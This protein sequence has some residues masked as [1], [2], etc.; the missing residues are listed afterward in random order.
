METWITFASR[1]RI[2]ILRPDGSDLH[3]LALDVPGQVNW[4]LGPL[5]AD[6]ER[7]IV[8]SYEEG[9]PWE[10]EVHTHLWMYHFRR[11]TLQE[12]A[13]Q[14]RLTPMTLCAALLPGETRMI[15]SPIIQHEQRIYSM[16]LDGSHAQELTGAGEGFAYG[17]ALSPDGRHIAHHITGPNDLPYRI[18]VMNVDG[19]H[20][21]E[22]AHQAGHLYFG[23][24]WSPDGA[25]LAYEDC[26]FQEDPGH[27]WADIALAT[28]DGR[29]KRTVTQ[30]QRQWF[31]TSFG[32]PQTRGGGSE[33]VQWSPDGQWLTYTRGTPDARTAWPFQPQR[34]DTDHFNRD[35][36]PEQARG[37][38]QVCLL[39]P[40]TQQ[41][42]EL[43]P[44]EP[45]VWNFRSRWSPDGD[46]LSFSRAHVGQ[47]SEVWAMD[48]DGA[49]ARL[50]T[51]GFDEMGADHARWLVLK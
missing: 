38:T 5:F 35:Y 45:L 12:I 39:N 2:G 41:V 10:H 14:G 37:G 19:T 13:T 30:G 47:P 31:G 29:A 18:R 40:F 46:Q 42:K 48:A 49:H 26:L 21:V 7:C 24:A 11:G 51:R 4:Q 20:K 43:T 32:T 1:G 33:M 15:A 3:A 25:W 22:V 9:K 6:A 17:I 36:L 16:D 34:P 8:T 44:Y 23:P 27:D 28:P 50:L